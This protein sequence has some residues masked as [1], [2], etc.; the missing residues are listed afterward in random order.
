MEKVNILGVNFSK[1]NKKEVLEHIKS[2]LIS[3]Q[4]H[5]IV[6][7]NAEFILAAQKDEEFFHILNHAD[8]AVLDG[9]G[10]QFACWATGNFIRRY[11]GADLVI[12]LLAIADATAAKVLILNWKDGLLSAEEINQAISDRFANIRLNIQNIDRNG[13]GL[14]L[15]AINKFEPQ[16]VISTLG[17]PFQEKLLYHNLT[18]L[19][20][21][22]VA[23]GIGGALDFLAGK[24]K[25]AP[26]IFR[27]IGIEWLWR[28]L[29]KPN[30]PSGKIIY[31]R[32][33]RIWNA[34]AVF[35]Y[36]F[37]RWQYLLPLFYRPN[38]ACWLYKKNGDSYS[39]LMVER[40]DQPGHWQL[41]Q[42]GTDGESIEVAGKRE[43]QEEL[44]IT[45]VSVKKIF[46][47]VNCYKFKKVRREEVQRHMGYKGQ[48]QAL[49]IAEYAGK[50]EDF[51]IN[52]WD[53]TDWKWVDVKDVISTTY[54]VR[55]EGYLKFLNKFNE[56]I[57]K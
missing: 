43:L 22:K 13:E 56:I 40:A 1:L 11:P 38:V 57:N 29:Q 8:L 23:I 4:P 27:L 36:K 52:F 32:Y 9:S 31:N 24:V 18:T 46:P 50:D 51:K 45:D 21:L 3:D 35:V 20:G 17:A 25:R 53:H 48:C 47:K 6:T 7:P 42:G 30:N 39:V 28:L 16:I 5:L 2:F 37:L 34:T 26:A 41:P 10:P 14:D 19:K 54:E 15:E 12:D 49:F 44:G 33:K 55:R